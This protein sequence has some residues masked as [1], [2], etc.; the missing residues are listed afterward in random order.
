MEESTQRSRDDINTECRVG[1]RWFG[2]SQP[3]VF[4]FGLS[5]SL[6]VH[7]IAEIMCLLF[8]YVSLLVLAIV[9]LEE[10]LRREYC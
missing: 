7:F 8:A 9:K 6:L 10:I 1:T 4:D 2:L 5:L 3:I